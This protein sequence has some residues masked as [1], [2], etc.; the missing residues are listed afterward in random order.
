[1]G[2]RISKPRQHRSL[3]EGLFDSKSSE[4]DWEISAGR[5]HAATSRLDY[6]WLNKPDE[7][8]REETLE[9]P[10]ALLHQR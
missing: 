1:M 3:A 6:V 9:V 7:P 5:T 4:E 10:Q 8:S 2:Q